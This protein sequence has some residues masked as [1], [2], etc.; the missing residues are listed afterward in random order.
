MEG[1]RERSILLLGLSLAQGG[2]IFSGE[3][4]SCINRRC[5]ESKTG[6]E[7][8]ESLLLAFSTYIIMRGRVDLPQVIRGLQNNV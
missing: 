2:L 4:S 5:P 8:V 1:L 3:A 6:L 7:H